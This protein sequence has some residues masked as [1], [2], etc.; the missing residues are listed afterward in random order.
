MEK[1]YLVYAGTYAEGTDGSGIY[2]FRMKDGVLIPAGVER[3]CSNPN[4]L[5]I[6]PERGYLCAVN[7]N[8]SDAWL[9]SYQI[10]KN[11]LLKFRSRLDLSGSGPCHIMMNQ[12]A[13]RIY[14]AYYE[15]GD[16][17]AAVLN[18]SGMITGVKC[19]KTYEGSSVHER[20]KS[21]HPH[22]VFMDIQEKQ[23]FVPDLG[24][25]Q[26]FVYDADDEGLVEKDVLS[27]D[28]GDGPRHLVFHSFGTWLYLVCEIGNTVYQFERDSGGRY[29]KKQ[30]I[31]LFPEGNGGESIAAAI[32]IT[33]DGR[34]LLVSNRSWGKA[35]MEEGSISSFSINQVNGNLERNGRFSSGGVHP[36]MIS[37]TADDQYLLVANQYSGE[38]VVYK[39]DA[40]TGKLKEPCSKVKV[41]QPAFVTAVETNMIKGD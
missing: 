16:I 37:L 14:Y 35:Q 15:S 26:V 28:G 34:Y 5:A 9:S 25:D 12:R 41:C 1:E 6:S 21:P 22:G 4:Y 36:R 2:T 3:N 33:S 29:R 10:E 17:G 20:Q 7:E 13:D 39:F 8:G 19:K 40:Q 23:L 32:T 30:R 27:V 38:I 24:T 11:G 31:P 18:E